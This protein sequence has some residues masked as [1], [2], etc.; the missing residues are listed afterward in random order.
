[1]FAAIQIVRVGLAGISPHSLTGKRL[2]QDRS[3]RLDGF[4]RIRRRAQDSFA[5]MP[6]SPPAVD[7]VASHFI[8][9][10]R[11]LADND[12]VDGAVASIPKR[13]RSGECYAK[14]NGHNAQQ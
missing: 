1:M 8:A 12:P 9:E 2:P 14:R 6:R 7:V 3:T 10:F 13:Q 11:N 5:V 4:L